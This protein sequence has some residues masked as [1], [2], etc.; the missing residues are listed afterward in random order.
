[1]AHTPRWHSSFAFQLFL[2]LFLKPVLHSIVTFVSL[3]AHQELCMA[4]FLNSISPRFPFVPFFL[5]FRLLPRAGRGWGVAGFGFSSCLSSL[6]SC[7]PRQPCFLRG[8]FQFGVQQLPAEFQN[9]KCFQISPYYGLKNIIFSKLTTS[10][11]R[12]MSKEC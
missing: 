2:K 8:L 10:I 1:M 11:L 9:F 3:S 4:P 12:R 6:A 5:E 7:T